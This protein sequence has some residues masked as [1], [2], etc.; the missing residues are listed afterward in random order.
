MNLELPPPD[1]AAVLHA[2]A[3]VDPTPER[4]ARLREAVQAVRK[5]IRREPT[6]DKF[7]ALTNRFT[8]P[9]NARK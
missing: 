9:I 6:G 8:N 5:R 1:L 3:L 7:H 2:A 4:L